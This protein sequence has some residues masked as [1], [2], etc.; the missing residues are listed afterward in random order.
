M[1]TTIILLQQASVNAIFLRANNLNYPPGFQPIELGE[2]T[3][4]SQSKAQLSVEKDLANDSEL[5]AVADATDA[6]VDTTA[7]TLTNNQPK[8]NNMLNTNSAL[9]LMLP[10][11]LVK[12]RKQNIIEQQHENIEDAEL[13]LKQKQMEEEEQEISKDIAKVRKL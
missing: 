10:T 4:T 13:K 1:V 5:S 11:N 7:S 2:P 6:T 12:M 8:E 9:N 3:S